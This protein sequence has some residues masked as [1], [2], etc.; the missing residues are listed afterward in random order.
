MN[1]ASVFPKNFPLRSI[2][3][4]LSL[5]VFVGFLG[6]FI[7]LSLPTR[8]PKLDTTYTPLTQSTPQEIGS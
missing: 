7:E 8:S 4:L 6:Y 5:L 3:I 1:F 2:L